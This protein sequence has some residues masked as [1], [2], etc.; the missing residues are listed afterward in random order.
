MVSSSNH[1]AE[2]YPGIG[3]GY[4]ARF[5]RPESRES[6]QAYGKSSGSDDDLHEHDAW[7]DP[8]HRVRFAASA[9]SAAP[10]PG[11]TAT[12]L[13]S[14]SEPNTGHGGWVA[15]TPA[16]AARER[17]MQRKSAQYN[18]GGYG[19]FNEKAT[20]QRSNKRRWW[21]IGG[22]VALIVI[23]AV[24]AGVGVAVSK[25]KN[26]G[27]ATAGVVASSSN[28]PS[29]FTKDPRLKQSFYAMCYT[30]FH[31]QYPTCGAV[32]SNVTEDIQLLSQL[33][34][35]LRLY[36][37]DCDTSE[38]VLTAIEQTK[39]NMTVW[40]GLWVDDNAQTWQRQVQTTQA[41]LKKHGAKHVEG[42]IVGNE[43]ILNG[44]SVATLLSKVNE[45]KAWVQSQNYN[46]KIATADA[47]SV[48]TTELAQGVDVVM[49]NVHAW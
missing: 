38:M 1:T 11:Q 21:L 26:K 41:V 19:D 37:A 9:P 47:G 48:V 44:G 20:S 42:L 43:Y 5:N 33:T 39:V 15:H 4:T 29:Q 45:V 18:A 34:T 27:A 12:L 31:T 3:A 16:L 13:N 23:I 46:V 8:S 35:R 24:G 6:W 30:P 36:G 40:L 7:S 49:A 25:S 2:S 14:T 10:A 22:I 32:Q 28:D 17:Y